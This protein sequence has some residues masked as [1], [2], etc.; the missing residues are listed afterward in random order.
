[1]SQFPSAVTG[2]AASSSS[3][4]QPLSHMEADLS[5]MDGSPKDMSQMS[6]KET[7]PNGTI[8]N[9]H[10]DDTKSAQPGIHDYEKFD[11]QGAYGYKGNGKEGGKVEGGK[12]GATVENGKSVETLGSQ[13]SDI[14]RQISG[15]GK[16]SK[17]ANTTSKQSSKQSQQEEFLHELTR[18]SVNG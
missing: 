5:Q 18:Q 13:L 16:G 1:M 3:G 8:P 9:G 12:E 17:E 6:S 10:R 15:V 14:Q 2:A 7:I 4:I 11:Y